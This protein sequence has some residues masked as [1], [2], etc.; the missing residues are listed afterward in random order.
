MREEM[1]V[2][3]VTVNTRDFEELFASEFMRRASAA[4]V[5]ALVPLE[6]ALTSFGIL[7]PSTISRMLSVLGTSSRSIT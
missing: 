6:D 2:V 7:G 4:L 5:R 3:G 1:R